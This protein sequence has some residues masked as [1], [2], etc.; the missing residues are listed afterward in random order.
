MQPDNHQNDWQQPPVA[1]SR[2]PYAVPPVQNQNDP[3]MSPR[4][5]DA[6]VAPNAS[7][8]YGAATTPLQG[9]VQSQIA[10]VPVAQTAQ[11]QPAQL[12]DPPVTA[13]T[14]LQ[15]LAPQEVVT[16]AAAQDDQDHRAQESGGADKRDADEAA[17]LRWQGSE[18][19][20][21]DRGAGWYVAMVFVVIALIA[22]AVF[23]LKSITFAIL[24]PI[25]AVALLIYVNRPPGILNY[26][27]SHKGLHINDKLYPFSQF[28]SFGVVRHNEVNSV[29]LVPRKRFQ[30]GQTL[31]FPTEIGEQLVDMLASRLPMKDTKL[32][33]IDKL[34]ARLRI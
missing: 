5:A 29:V 21:H 25:M 14:P 17:L 15:T 31:Y 7:Q 10:S 24:V 13:Q 33:A 22:L 19:L 30:I 23:V 16:P 32:D 3:Q 20:Q 18:Y 8:D 26:A 28:K 6:P 34:L 1:P 27:L 12:F 4:P 11:E 2:A 9:P